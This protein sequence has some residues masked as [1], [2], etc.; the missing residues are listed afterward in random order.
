MQWIL[1]SRNNTFLLHFLRMVQLS[2][3]SWQ[4]FSLKNVLETLQYA[5]MKLQM[6][7]APLL[8]YTFPKVLEPGATIRYNLQWGFKTLK[9]TGIVSSVKENKVTVRLGEGPFRG[10]TAKHSFVDEGNMTACY[11]EMSFQGFTDIPEATFAAIMDKAN[12]VYGIY[13]RKDTRDMMLAYEAQKKTQSIEALEQ[14][15]TAG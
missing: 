5:P 9:W 4:E 10:F 14:S 1:N 6:G 12:I 13:A 7:H 2:Q 15:A 11:D 3:T 8:H